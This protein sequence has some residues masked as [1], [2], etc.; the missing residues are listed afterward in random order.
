MTHIW[1]FTIRYNNN[2]E[3]SL[4]IQ[5]ST[6]EALGS[7]IRNNI[8]PFL[9]FFDRSFICET[10]GEIF[11]SYEREVLEGDYLRFQYV[12]PKIPCHSRG[13][14]KP[15]QQEKTVYRILD[16]YSNE[17]IVDS[18]WGTYRKGLSIGITQIESNSIMRLE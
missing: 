17:E 6:K 12:S 3:N 9:P 16:H 18:F 5:A 8:E 13:L 2:V 15:T 1:V 10:K 7:H 11:H 14:I 4:A